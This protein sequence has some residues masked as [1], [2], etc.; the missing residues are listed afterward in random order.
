MYCSNGFLLALAAV[1]PVYL[2]TTSAIA[3]VLATKTSLL[4]APCPPMALTMRHGSGVVLAAAC[5]FA[6]CSPAAARD[7]LS[8]LQNADVCWLLL[9]ADL[10]LRSLGFAGACHDGG[11]PAH[12]EIA[13]VCVRPAIGRTRSGLGIDL[14]S[15]LDCC[16]SILLMG[17]SRCPDVSAMSGRKSNISRRPFAA[18]PASGLHVWGPLFA[19]PWPFHCA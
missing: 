1:E 12:H 18:W 4:R 9:C 2:S 5:L 11:A 10:G 7:L 19:L 16:V 3:K 15:S 17:R 14:Y 13:C 6:V 8:A